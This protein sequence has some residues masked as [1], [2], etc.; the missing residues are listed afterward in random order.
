[1]RQL[2]FA[3]IFFLLLA[4]LSISPTSAQMNDLTFAQNEDLAELEELMQ[5]L[6]EET[7]VATKTKLNS[8]YVPGMVTVLQGR[9]LEALGIATVWEAL[10]LVPGM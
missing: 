1:M 10:S 3:L 6:D 4:P 2:Q 5:I 8:D 9:D 7:T